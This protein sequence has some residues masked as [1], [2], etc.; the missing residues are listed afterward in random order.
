MSK[1]LNGELLAYSAGAAAVV[2]DVSRRLHQDQCTT[3]SNPIT[4]N[5]ALSMCFTSSLQVKCMRQVAS[6]V[7]GHSNATI[8]ALDWYD[9]SFRS[10]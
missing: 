6:L 4:L 8:T 3:S 9:C 1:L 5:D 10:L 7:G 2:I